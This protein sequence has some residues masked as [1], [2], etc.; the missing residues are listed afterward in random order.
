MRRSRRKFSKCVLVL[1]D[2]GPVCK[3]LV[4]KSNATLQIWLRST[5][6]SFPLLKKNVKGDQFP[7]NE[8][9]EASR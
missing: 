9:P 6:M 2:N 4:H 3:S 1:Q 7:F 8:G 5:I